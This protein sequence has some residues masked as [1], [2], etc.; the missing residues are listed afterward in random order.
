MGSINAV[1]ASA[2]VPRKFRLCIQPPV[3]PDPQAG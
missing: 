2:A 1:A 3:D